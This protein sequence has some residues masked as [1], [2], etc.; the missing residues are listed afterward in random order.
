M[1]AHATLGPSSSASQL[2]PRP[3]VVCREMM[4]C[5]GSSHYWWE[6]EG[7]EATRPPPAT[8]SQLST[9]APWLTINPAQIKNIPHLPNMIA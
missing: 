2:S 4:A 3:T 8:W 9:D 6:T 1:A 5:I 7:T